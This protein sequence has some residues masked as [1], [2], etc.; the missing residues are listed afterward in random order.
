MN[1]EK[2]ARTAG[3][4]DVLFRVLRKIMFICA[5]ALVCVMCVLT[6]V[7][8]INP[9]AKIGEDF[10]LVDIGPVTFELAEELEPDNRTI[11]IYA[12]IYTALGLAAAA[13]VYISLGL[14]RKILEPMAHG[15]PFH[16]DTASHI[17]KLG[18]CCLALGIAQNIGGVV[19]AVTAMNTFDLN[20]LIDSGTIHSIT[21][22]VQFDLTFIVVFFILLLLSYVFAYGSELQ[23]LSDETV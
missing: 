17:K 14:V 18:F 7:N 8:F 11:L 13:V 23:Q 21:L 16:R 10:N 3:K 12:W 22:N 6:I 2:L 20:N 15:L 19:E 1:I 4:L 5:I 9:E